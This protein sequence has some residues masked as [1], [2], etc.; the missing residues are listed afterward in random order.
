MLLGRVVLV[1]PIGTFNK[2]F[3]SSP[4]P[5]ILHFVF[6]NCSDKHHNIMWM[7]FWHDYQFLG[8]LYSRIL[9]E[10][11]CLIH[12]IADRLLEWG[13]NFVVGER[14]VGQPE[15]WGNVGNIKTCAQWSG[16]IPEN[17]MRE[18]CFRTSFTLRGPGRPIVYTVKQQHISALEKKLK[19][20]I[21][22]TR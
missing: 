2:C 1:K 20:T 21:L 11:K 13:R 16:H 12:K 19:E 9:L 7:I 17:C 22:K 5:I 10:K 6:L 18:R 15:K 4:R 3:S 8:D 14:S